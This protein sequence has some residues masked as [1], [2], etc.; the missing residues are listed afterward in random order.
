MQSF[1]RIV[2]IF[3]D[4]SII[5]LSMNKKKYIYIVF[6]KILLDFLWLIQSFFKINF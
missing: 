2:K 3:E 5:Q 4:N 1:M 6:N